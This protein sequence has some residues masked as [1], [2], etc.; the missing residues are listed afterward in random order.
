MKDPMNELDELSRLLDAEFAEDMPVPGIAPHTPAFKELAPPLQPSRKVV[1]EATIDYHM[2]R[3]TLEVLRQQVICAVAQLEI[4][5]R[6]H[7]K[8]VE[9]HKAIGG[10]E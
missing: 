1:A 9:A 4:L 2:L 5:E 6:T 3:S 10:M 7:H 8:Y